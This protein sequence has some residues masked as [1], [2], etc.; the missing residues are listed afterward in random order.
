MSWIIERW[1]WIIYRLAH[2]SLK[3][4]CERN[5]GFAYLFQLW[6]QEWRTKHPIS[7]ELEKAT[8]LFFNGLKD[9]PS[10]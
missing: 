7:P 5:A 1:D 6:L 10:E 8:E 4:M 2:K 3:R 9:W